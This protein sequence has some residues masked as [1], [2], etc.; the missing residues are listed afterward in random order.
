MDYAK[1]AIGR[2]LCVAVG[3]WLS[4]ADLRAAE[5]ARFKIVY[6]T[7]LGGSQWDQGREVV[8]YP[9]GSVLVGGQTASSNMPTTAGV[10]QPKYAGDDPALGHPGIYGGDCFLARLS[11]DGSRV[12]AATYFGGSKQ[13]RNVYGL[14]LDRQGNLVITSTTRSDDIPTTRGCFQ[15]KFAGGE[16]ECFAAKI[17]SDL[18]RLI[19]CTYVGGSGG[20]SPR[21]G[22]ALDRDDNV[23]LVGTTSS[24]NYPTTPGVYQEKP[25]G[26][27]TAFLTKLRADGSGLVSSTLF[28]GSADA[29]IIGARID[30]EG[31]IYVAG[32]T[33]SQDLPVAADAAQPKYAGQA[34]IFL[35]KF[36][37]DASRLLWA[38]YLGGRGN[39]FAEYRLRILPDGS[40]LLTG[41]TAS[42][43][44]PTTG[45]AFQRKL[46][47]RTDG[48][49]VKLSPDGKRFALATLLGGSGEEF[50]LMP[51]VDRE[52]NIYI[53]GQTNSRDL[54]VTP[55]AIQKTYGGGTNDGVLAVLSPDGST[56]LY[57]T[58]LGGSGDDMIRSIAL[59]R[60][61]EVYLVGHTASPDF[62]VTAGA[63]QSR[64]GGGS[65]DIYVVKLVPT[66]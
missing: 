24:R 44:F 30:A 16:N 50:F 58:Y 11:A 52:G 47:G 21:G 41:T 56:L 43:D 33:R 8:P 7:Y 54:P 46:R 51:T 10:V 38:T 27:Q 55:D 37:A 17:T 53:V 66:R 32:H 12:L 63:F 15:P 42:P 25:A 6:A 36:S 61:G 18:K 45:R 14:E 31:S 64:F 26:P 20:E 60:G 48:I 5:P 62:P 29:H 59:G 28:G 3:I 9:D 2:I 23:C 1:R 35:A 40:V 65:G 34:D 49:L 19:W 13:E 39:E 22:L 4:G 57:C